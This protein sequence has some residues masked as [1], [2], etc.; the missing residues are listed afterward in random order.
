MSRSLEH[1]GYLCQ[2]KRTSI[3]YLIGHYH[4]PRLAHV[5]DSLQ[6]VHLKGTPLMSDVLSAKTIAASLDE[7]WSPRVIGELD[8]AYVKVAKIQG[9]FVWH[10][11]DHEDELFFV[12]GGSLRIELEGQ[13]TVEIG[14]GQLFVV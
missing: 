2:P 5:S 4:H 10:S 14:E 7:L 3:R 8:D 1:R 13:P 12:L 6:R 11:H 9:E